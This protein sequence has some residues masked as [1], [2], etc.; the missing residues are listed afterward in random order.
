MIEIHTGEYSDA[1]RPEDVQRLLKEIITAARLGKSIGLVSE[2]RTWT[3]LFERKACSRYHRHRRDEYRPFHYIASS[4]RRTGTSGKGDDH[5]SREIKKPLKAV[6][7]L[8]LIHEIQVCGYH[9]S[10]LPPFS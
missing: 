4:V 3:E 2:C 6:F 7:L 10:V 5:E 1:T 9:P 8:S